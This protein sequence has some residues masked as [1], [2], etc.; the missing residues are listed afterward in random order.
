MNF[1]VIIHMSGMFNIIVCIAY[2]MRCACPCC[3]FGFY[4]WF[5]VTTV[6]FFSLLL[7]VFF[8]QLQVNGCVYLIN[9]NCAGAACF[10]PKF[11]NSPA[12]N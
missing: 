2:G 6:A 3:V 11:K 4:V 7:N 12:F 8:Y 5:L 10:K 1:N 9:R